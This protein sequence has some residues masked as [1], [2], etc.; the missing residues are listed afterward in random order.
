MRAFERMENESAKAFAAFAVYRDLGS[1]R[2]LQ[3]AA[4]MYAGSTSYV[5]QLKRWSSRFDWV[6]RARAYDDWR[7]ME[8]Q[9]ALADHERRSAEDFAEREMR[10]RERSLSIREKAMDQAEK[11][12]Q[13]P[14]AEQRAIRDEDGREIELVFVPAR[15]SKASAVGLHNMAIGRGPVESQEAEAELDFSELTEEE[16]Q[17]IVDLAGK[18][19]IRRPPR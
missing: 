6:A 17:T 16:L 13:W 19:G 14:L 12:L 5:A 2:S 10:L 15:W 8:L 4:E 7:E 1:G 18:L 3:K 9:S 11:M